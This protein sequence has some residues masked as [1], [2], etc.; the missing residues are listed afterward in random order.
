MAAASKSDGLIEEEEVPVKEKSSV[1]GDGVAAASAMAT[2]SMSKVDKE[3][4][5]FAGGGITVAAAEATAE[6]SK[7]AP[8]GGK[9]PFAVGGIAAAAAQAAAE[10]LRVDS[11]AGKSPFAGGGIV[12]AAAMAAATKN[13]PAFAEKQPVNNRRKVSITLPGSTA[14]AT[15]IP[16]FVEKKVESANPLVANHRMKDDDTLQSELTKFV[17]GENLARFHERTL[18]RSLNLANQ[19]ISDGMTGW[20]EYGNTGMLER[21]VDR[22]FE[23]MESLAC[24][25]AE[26]ERW[27]VAVDIF[28]SLLMRCE[29]YLPL[30][31]PMTLVAL[32]D[33]S[34]ALQQASQY[35]QAQ[36]VAGR[37]SQRLALY[38]SEQEE[39]F[40]DARSDWM[41]LPTE[42]RI[43][44][45]LH[46]AGDFLSMLEEFT[47]SMERLLGRQFVRSLGPI[48]SALLLNYSM[49][50]DS[51]AVLANCHSIFAGQDETSKSFRYW[52]L[53]C[54]NYRVAFEGWAKRGQ[55]LRHTNVS[56]LAC[57]MARCLREM[58][59]LEKAVQILSTVLLGRKERE[60]PPTRS[61]A[62]SPDRDKAYGSLAF[63]PPDRT[64]RNRSLLPKSSAEDEK[65]N[66][67]CLWSLA[68]YTVELNPSERGRIRALSFLHASAESFR[69]AISVASPSKKVHLVDIL[70]SVEGEARELFQPLEEAE[71]ESLQEQK[72]V[73]GRDDANPIGDFRRRL[74]E[75]A[76]QI[77]DRFVSA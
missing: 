47:K 61:K 62:K 19:A 57:G 36:L 9:S 52:S 11:G 20:F 5:P 12:A 64:Q 50:G 65:I 43:S 49:L 33:L 70:K 41:S 37:A 69:R 16:V 21:S 10:K 24:L 31:H 60:S 4:L 45:R 3:A 58:G 42:E 48:H 53:S 39:N 7:G 6:K 34:G 25:H 32:L 67:L 56:T 40:L 28:R 73:R 18:L 74:E 44:F 22:T 66:G 13:A 51:F 17:N 35:H 8:D 15:V 55:S 38:L 59:Q 75:T 29:Q 71:H 77:Q 27:D 2:A 54:K 63:L 23:V 72:S 1:G 46:S 14:P 30:Y 76:R 26:Q 68:V